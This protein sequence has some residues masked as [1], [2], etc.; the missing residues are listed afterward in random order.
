MANVANALTVEHETAKPVAPV[1]EQLPASETAAIFQII[2]R[3][4][5][6]PNVDI[7]KMQR[8]WEMHDKAQAVRAKTAYAAAFAEMQPHL[9]EIPEYGKGHGAIT[10]ALW[11]DINDLIKPV[12]AAHGFGISFRPGRDGQAITVT[13][14]LSHREGHS[15]EATMLLPLDTSG[16]KNAVQAVGSSTSYGKRYTAAALLNLTSRGEDDDGKKGG[17][18]AIDPTPPPAKSSASLKRKDE[19]GEDAWDRLIKELRADLQDCTLVNLPKLRADY[20]ERA[21][22]DRWPRAWLDA[23]A[24]EFDS[25]EDLL[26][27]RE[28]ERDLINDEV[29]F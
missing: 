18:K 27:K 3:A 5:R 9:P 21:R 16:S 13:A 2:E 11:E 15:E 1:P 20:R 25:H 23:L 12:L 19:N 29:P 10:Y 24:N 28:A 22:A 8:L 6:D 7:D 17:G 26:E 4:A 14:I